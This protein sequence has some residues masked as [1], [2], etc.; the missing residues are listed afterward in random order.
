MTWTRKRGR[1]EYSTWDGVRCSGGAARCVAASCLGAIGE[2]L[3]KAV[4][5]QEIPDENE[6]RGIYYGVNGRSNSTSNTISVD[7]QDSSNT[8]S[9]SKIKLRY[10]V[11]ARFEIE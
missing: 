6:V 4:F 2:S 3:G 1:Y 10:S 7:G 5:V 9:F 11:L 8:L